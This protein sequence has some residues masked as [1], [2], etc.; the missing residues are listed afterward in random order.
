[1]RDLCIG[2]LLLFSLKTLEGTSLLAEQHPIAF[3]FSVCLSLAQN[4]SKAVLERKEVIAYITTSFT[5]STIR[6]RRT[7]RTRGT[8]STRRTRN[9]QRTRFTLIQEQ[10]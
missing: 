8:T 9:T 5:R 6:T 7:H 10:W 1:M 2:I 4:K 3:S